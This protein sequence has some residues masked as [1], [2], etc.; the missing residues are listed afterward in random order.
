MRWHQSCRSPLGRPGSSFRNSGLHKLGLNLFAGR[1]RWSVTA[2]PPVGIDRAAPRVRL[3][4]VGSAVGRSIISNAVA[5]SSVLS[6]R[7]RCLVGLIMPHA[8]V[9]PVDVHVVASAIAAI[10]IERVAARCLHGGRAKGGHDVACVVGL[11]GSAAAGLVSVRHLHGH[12]ILFAPP[13]GKPRVPPASNA[14]QGL[15]ARRGR[16]LGALL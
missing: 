11:A 14:G 6:V 8:A 16:D 15:P 10:L 5:R 13:N 12:A 9:G 3:H 1:G 7:A 4:S 2:P